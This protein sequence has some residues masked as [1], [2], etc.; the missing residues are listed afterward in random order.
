MRRCEEVNQNYSNISSQV[1]L[2]STTMNSR[3]ET[4]AHP[5]KWNIKIVG[6]NSIPD[7]GVLCV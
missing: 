7:I 5:D 2:V 6:S 3:S 1:H 4:H